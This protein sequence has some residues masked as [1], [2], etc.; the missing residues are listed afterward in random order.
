MIRS[1]LFLT[2]VCITCTATAGERIVLI[3]QPKR[4]TQSEIRKSAKAESEKNID[5]GYNADANVI[6]SFA[7][8]EYQSY[9]GGRYVNQPIRFRLMTPDTLKPGKKYPLVIWLHGVGESGDDNARQ[10]SHVQSTIEF[11]AG[12]NKLDMFVLATQC[13][14]DNTAWEVSLSDEGKGDAPLV[15]LSEILDAVIEEY[16][17]DTQ[18]LGVFGLCSGGTATWTLADMHPNR[19]AAVVA[20]TSAPAGVRPDSF[21]QTAV[22]AFNNKDDP[23]PYEQTERFVEMI[24]EQGGNAYISLRETGGHDSWSDALAKKKVLCW[25]TLQTLGQRGPPQEMVCRHRSAVPLFGMFVFPILITVVA[26]TVRCFYKPR[27]YRNGGRGSTSLH[28]DTT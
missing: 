5:G 27:F 16:P 1:L 8:M 24:N 26:L 22:W 13:P 12:K 11:L 20:C 17:V 4:I 3:E 10:L 7:V 9:T 14:P 2:F 28:D 25:M 23:V 6:D 21:R 18:K 19:F 15:V